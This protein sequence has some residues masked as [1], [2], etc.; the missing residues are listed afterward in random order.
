MIY[1]QVH[2]KE[3][4]YLETMVLRNL[5]LA[6]TGAQGVKM[7]V[8]VCVRDIMLTSTLEEFLRVLEGLK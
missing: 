2:I 6:P 4:R 7:S 8:R 1:S 5:F 3:L